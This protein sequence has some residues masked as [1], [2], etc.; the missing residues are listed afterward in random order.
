M[1]IFLT[2]KPSL[3]H[4]SSLF[5]D[6]KPVAIIDSWE[7]DPETASSSHI[8]VMRENT[9]EF[10]VGLA[11]QGQP[12]DQERW[13]L[14]AARRL[15]VL[16]ECQSLYTGSPLEGAMQHHSIVFVSGKAFLASDY[17]TNLANEGEALVKL[18]RRVPK[19]DAKSG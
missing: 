7:A 18:L 13:L 5:D 16:L 1:D 17:G 4:L 2:E 10:P 8:V 14:D 15:S 6:E 12:G 3:H 19:L 9:S 11:F